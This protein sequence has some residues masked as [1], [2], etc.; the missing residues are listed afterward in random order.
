MHKQAIIWW[1]GDWEMKQMAPLS[2]H[3]YYI[4]LFALFGAPTHSQRRATINQPSHHVPEI[5]PCERCLE[6]WKI[7]HSYHEKKSLTFPW[8]TIY[9]ATMDGQK[10][11]YCKLNCHIHCTRYLL[12]KGKTP[13][14]ATSSTVR[15][16][17][18]TFTHTNRTPHLSSNLLQ[19][20]GCFAIRK[21]ISALYL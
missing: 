3:Q 5:K 7:I 11:M 2:C 1:T 6:K 14:T 13:L 18:Q 8:M 20:P 15:E 16:N 4:P 9:R 10:S 19:S 17:T 21:E 12:P